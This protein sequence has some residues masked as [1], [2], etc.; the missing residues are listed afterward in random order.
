M[1]MSKETYR[2]IVS[3]YSSL[4]LT[5]DDETDALDFAHDLLCAEADA[6]AEK[7][8]Y[9]TNSIGRLEAAAHE[10]FQLAGDIGSE[11]FES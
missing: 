5:E 10:V 11:E 7:Y 8:P 9:A 3:R 1:V 2:E 4:L 6:T